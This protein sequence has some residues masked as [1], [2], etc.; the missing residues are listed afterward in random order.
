M[1][2]G[3]ALIIKLK[4]SAK[5]TQKGNLRNPSGTSNIY[6]KRMCGI[7][8]LALKLRVNFNLSQKQGYQQPSHHA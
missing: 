6:V 5:V 8:T 2:I 4:K 3:S 7:S 1:L